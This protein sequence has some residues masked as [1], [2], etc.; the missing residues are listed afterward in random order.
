MI[1]AL[2]GFLVGTV[3]GSFIKV[4]ADR[5]LIKKELGGRSYCPY[6][7]AVLRWYDL[8]PVISYIF[9][10]GKCRYCHKRIGIEYPLTEILTGIL[11]GYLFWQSFQNLQFTINFQFAIFLAEFLF[12][13]FFISILVSLA[14]TDLK[15]MLIPD[16]I[17]LPSI[18]F[19]I[20]YLLTLAV[21]KIGYLYYYL[22]QS[23]VGKLLLPP[24]SPYFQRHALMTVESVLY[25][26]LTGLLLGGFFLGLIILT[27]GKGMGGGDVKLG[28]FLGLVLG[29][30]N[31]LAALMMAF[32]S[33]SIVAIILVISGKKSFGQQIP[34]GPFLVFGSIV[35]L[36]WGKEIIN[37]YLALSI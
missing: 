1:F 8:F 10:K 2:F 26:A 23:S 18:I 33:G 37:W 12:K 9:L 13:V 35:A 6:C 21:M 17:I 32:I 36:F 16:R 25:P 15:K 22:S 19:A 14:I 4:L 30:P 27:K 34:F 24:H 7:K 5:S 29:F 11:I 20:I 28:V 31:S 3:L